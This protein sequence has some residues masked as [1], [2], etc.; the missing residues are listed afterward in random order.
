MIQFP[1]CFLYME[2]MESRVLLNYTCVQLAMVEW[3]NI[4]QMQVKWLFWS[5]MQS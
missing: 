1:F 4:L 5:E 3:N 2:K